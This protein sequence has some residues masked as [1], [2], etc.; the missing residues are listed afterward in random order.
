MIGSFLRPL[1][2]QKALRFPYSLQNRDT[3]EI[4]QPESN[5]KE[6]DTEEQPH[7]PGWAPTTTLST[8]CLKTPPPLPRGLS[9]MRCQCPVP[10]RPKDAALQL[11]ATSQASSWTWTSFQ[12]TTGPHSPRTVSAEVTSSGGGIQPF[13]WSPPGRER[14]AGSSERTPLPA[15]LSG[16]EQEKQLTQQPLCSKIVRPH[17]LQGAGP[18]APLPQGTRTGLF[19]DFAVLRTLQNKIP[20]SCLHAERRWRNLP[21]ESD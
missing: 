12:G 8:R 20:S 5:P 6:Q 15:A 10:Q 4:W 2:E 21:N 3:L 9:N 17:R 14:T 16:T 7:A 18:R 19:P 11:T 13:P 1:Q